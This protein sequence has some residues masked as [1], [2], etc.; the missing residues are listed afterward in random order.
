MRYKL[1]KGWIAPGQT[2]GGE[3]LSKMNIINHNVSVQEYNKKPRMSFCRDNLKHLE[4]FNKWKLELFM[5]H[6][7]RSVLA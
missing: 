1:K 2:C 7:D 4:A 3:K 6:L 5:A